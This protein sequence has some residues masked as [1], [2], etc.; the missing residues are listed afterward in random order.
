MIQALGR[1]VLA[2]IAVALIGPAG[3]TSADAPAARR[4]AIATGDETGVYYLLGSAL[5]NI[6]TER[7][8]GLVASALETTGSGF[9]VQAVE[10]GRAQLAFSQADVAYLAMQQGTR[11]HPSPY[12]RLRAMAVLYVN[13]VQIVTRRGSDMQDLD[14]LASRRVGVGAPDSGTE[15]AAHII[16]REQSLQQRIHAEQLGAAAVSYTHL[17]LPTKA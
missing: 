7:L 13:A 10:E 8:P 12:R 17:T 9:N 4:L 14:D 5:A 2:G 16:L 6:F 3:C 11:G 1:L 15:V